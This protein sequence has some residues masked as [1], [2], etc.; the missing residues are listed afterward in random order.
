MISKFRTKEYV[1]KVLNENKKYI[2]HFKLMEELAVI[3][4]NR[5]MKNGYLSLDIPETEI[6]LDKNGKPI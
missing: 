3:L 2:K 5:R 4:K 1:K 6:P